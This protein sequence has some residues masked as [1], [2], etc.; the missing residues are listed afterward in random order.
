[1]TK[2]KN[3]I[4][5]TRKEHKKKHNYFFI[6]YSFKI[7]LFKIQIKLEKMPS[8]TLHYFDARGRAELSRLLF[9]AA[10]VAFA[11]KRYSYQDWPAQK[12]RN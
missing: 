2:Q 10:G 11:D 4:K 3:K 12:P 8:Y 6:Q 1:M 5:R 7:F 9:H